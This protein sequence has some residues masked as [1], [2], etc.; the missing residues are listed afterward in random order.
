M[1]KILTK[2]HTHQARFKTERTFSDRET[3]EAFAYADEIL[4]YR[5]AVQI[6]ANTGITG[7]WYEIRTRHN[8]RGPQNAAKAHAENR[9]AA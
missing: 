2:H 5:W 7:G 1:Y 3:D 8:P 9:P 6:K 4:K